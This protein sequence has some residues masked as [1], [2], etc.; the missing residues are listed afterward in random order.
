MAK[1][2]LN[3][4]EREEYIIGSIVRA[5]QKAVKPKRKYKARRSREQIDADNAKIAEQKKAKKEAKEKVKAEA[6]L[7]HDR[8]H[9]IFRFKE[10]LFDS[11]EK[12]YLTKKEIPDGTPAFKTAWR[13]AWQNKKDTFKH[14]G[15]EY[16]TDL[17]MG[18]TQKT[19]LV[20]PER[21]EYFVGALAKSITK[22]AQK[23]VKDIF[24]KATEG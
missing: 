15:D 4:P 3:P 24:S 18:N 14:K 10:S 8:S 19:L 21:E 7:K 5:G 6:K 12:E 11:L 23:H 17:N 1:S 16:S 13:N 20:S 9:G 22:G 2:M